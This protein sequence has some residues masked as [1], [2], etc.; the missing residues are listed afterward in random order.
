MFGRHLFLEPPDFLPRSAALVTSRRNRLPGWYTTAIRV[1]SAVTSSDAVAAA[2]AAAAVVV[3]ISIVTVH[4]PWHGR[5]DSTGQRADKDTGPPQIVR[6]TAIVPHHIIGFHQQFTSWGPPIPTVQQFL[7]W[8]SAVVRCLKEYHRYIVVVV[9]VVVVVLVLGVVL[10]KR[11]R[12]G[13]HGGFKRLGWWC[14]CVV[15]N[16]NVV[17]RKR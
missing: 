12:R 3:V 8:S 1:T 6:R 11:Q 10:Y 5:E 15:S 7:R 17:G 2:T 13:N 14:S 9:V 16:Q 4:P